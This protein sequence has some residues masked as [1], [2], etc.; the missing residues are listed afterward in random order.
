MVAMPLAHVSWAIADN[1]DRPACDAFFIDLFG[2]ET[3]HEMLETPEVAHF[4]FDREERLMMVGDVM[5]IPIAPGGRGVEPD[6][7]TGE[8]LRR[9]AGFNRW[10]GVALR[11]PDVEAAARWFA[12][13]GFKLHFDPGMEKVY[14]LVGRGQ[15]MGMRLEL[16][17]QDLPGDPRNDPAWTPAKWRDE[18]PLGIEGLQAIGLSAPSLDEARALFS[19]RLD[20]PELGT[21][22]L[23]GD[24]A[25]C[26]AFH[27]GDCVLEAM[28]P[29]DPAS[30]LARHLQET[31]GI[32][33]LTF[34][35]KDA[36]TA[37]EYLR[38]KGLSLTGNLA[39]RFA[40]APEQAY[41]RLIRFTQ[42]EVPGYPPIG[43]RLH[44]PGS[45]AA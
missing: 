18:H 39:D 31:K 29:R 1:A 44:Q 41:G 45:F 15:V 43:S 25:D 2:A 27:M 24:D 38:G 12:A 28:V 40:I 5:L 19:A 20:W 3:A 22:T 26:V 35:V 6:S 7:P 9:N 42:N 14:F 36:A 4:R 32:Y 10:L 8:M 16:L 11:V 34:K 13:R 30:P 33:C 21:R 23:P 37:A 17:N